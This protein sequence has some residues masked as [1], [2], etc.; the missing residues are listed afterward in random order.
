MRKFTLSILFI[1]MA[2]AGYST[3]WTIVNSGFAFSPATL[4]INEGDTVVFTLMSEHN[5]VEV[6]QAT[7]NMNGTTPLAGGWALPLGGGMVLPADL[8]EG[9]HFYVCQPHASGG[10]KGMIIVEGTTSTDDNQNEPSFSFYPN[11]STGLISLST[12]NSQTGKNI[13]VEVFDIHGNQVYTG[14][15]D[16]HVSLGTIDLSGQPK[17]MYFIRVNDEKG[18]RSKKLIL[19]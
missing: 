6:S 10:M 18:I 14:A 5:S 3:T 4:T 9:T 13:K 16:D 17:G 2:F 11:P 19:Q 8:T 15:G 1:T 12:E 7:W